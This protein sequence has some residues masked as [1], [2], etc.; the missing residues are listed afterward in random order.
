MIRDILTHRSSMGGTDL[1]AALD[2]LGRVVRR[3]AVVFVI[4]DFIDD[5]FG[6]SLALCGRRHEICAVHIVD[7]HERRLPDVGLLR[8]EDAETGVGCL[9]DTRQN[10][11]LSPQMYAGGRSLELLL[12][13]AGVDRFTVET[14]GSSVDPILRYLR[15]RD[16]GGRRGRHAP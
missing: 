6:D 16:G 7:P 10:L 12:R 8:L 13:Q 14:Q 9:V 3:R 2:T 15:R 5:A 11:P 4:S 1:A